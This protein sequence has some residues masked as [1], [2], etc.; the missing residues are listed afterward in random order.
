MVRVGLQRRFLL[1][2]QRPPTRSASANGSRSRARPPRRF[3]LRVS[4][5]TPGCDLYP[6]NANGRLASA[7]HQY[8]S[9]LAVDAIGYFADVVKRETDSRCLVGSFYGYVI[10]LAGE[11]RQAIA[12]HSALRRL[13]DHPNIDFIAGIPLLDFRNL[14]D[15]YNPYTSATESIYAAGKAVLQ[16]K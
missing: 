4:A 3:P 11:P 10:Q 9:E 1:R 15:G 6:D 8:N 14:T 2:L 12:G 16:R 13:I 7:Y 5:S